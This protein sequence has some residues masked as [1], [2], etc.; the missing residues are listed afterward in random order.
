M[1]NLNPKETNTRINLISSFI[2]V[3]NLLFY[4]NLYSQ[5][6]TKFAAIGDYGA[7]GPNELAVS[8]MVK[9]W[10]PDFIITL[11]D[12]NYEYGCPETIDSNIGQYYHDYIFPYA[13]SF[14]NGSDSNR[15][16]PCIGNHE[17]YCCP[18]SCYTSNPYYYAKP[19]RDY[20]TLPNNERYYD[21]VKGNVHFFSMNSDL[22]GYE[23]QGTVYEPDGIDSNSVQAQWLK[24]KLAA[25]T[26]RW[27]IVYFHHPPYFSIQSP[28][29]DIFSKLRWPFKEWGASIVLT[30][31]AH[32]YERLNIDS[33]TYII[34]GLGGEEFD[35]SEIEER[36]GSQI[37]YVEN[38]GAQLITSYNDSLVFKFYSIDNDLIDSY[39]LLPTPKILKLTSLLE[40]PLNQT[41][42]MMTP[43]TVSVYL[44]N[45][46][47]PYSIVDSARGK[48]NSKGHKVFN[49]LRAKNGAEYYIVV[50]HRNSIETW[51]SVPKEF[52]SDTLAYNFTTLAS[53]A[54]GNNLKLIN[55][56]F[57]IYSGDTN[58]DGVVDGN[59]TYYIE[60]SAFNYIGGYI[61]ADLNGDRITDAID[62][63]IV[64]E[65]SFGIIT[66]KRP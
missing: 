44:R 62:L 45:M 55:G 63:S 49:F 60:N 47:S 10:N 36:S 16:F 54:Y 25:S 41:T 17:L 51:S 22:G 39:S 8:N 42:N 19:Y 21:Y 38:F 28:Y 11:G 29:L 27:N 66:I 31:H 56:K 26:S 3:F 59:D 15:F 48:L 58:H 20:F 18:N 13:G 61:T 35:G 6:I 64:D 52:S 53:Q 37:I 14:G 2:I 30:G 40:G 1:N 23:A 24:Q 9:S 32:W 65:N 7:A 12:N 57:C 43:D 46:F 5:P 50:K 33:F 4:I 34:N